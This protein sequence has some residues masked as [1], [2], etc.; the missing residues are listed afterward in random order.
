MEPLFGVVLVVPVPVVP[1][2]LLPEPVASGVVLLEPVPMLP[3]VP[4]LLVPVV[5]LPLFGVVLI[6]PAPDPV[7]VLLPMLPLVPVV[8]VVLLPAPFGLVWLETPGEVVELPASGVVLEDPEVVP[9]VPCEVPVVLLV[10]VAPVVDWL[11]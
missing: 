10:P 3:L 4:V 2:V 8:P 7:V 5:L 9:A 6:V 11:L 1:L